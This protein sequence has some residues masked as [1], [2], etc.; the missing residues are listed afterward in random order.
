M[1]E[2]Q[3]AMF[4]YDPSE[5]GKRGFMIVGDSDRRG[6][7]LYSCWKCSMGACH[8]HWKDLGDEQIYQCMHWLALEIAE[9]AGVSI[10]NIRDMMAENVR[11]FR[12]YD[13]KIGKLAIGPS[14]SIFQR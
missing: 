10:R 2:P 6:H 4:L 11:G 12:D 7:G 13:N 14:S 3:K 5:D 9:F 1:I 8:S